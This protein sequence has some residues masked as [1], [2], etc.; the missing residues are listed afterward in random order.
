[1]ILQV[2]AVPWLAVADTVCCDA[3]A[4]WSEGGQRPEEGGAVVTGTDSGA[5]EHRP[6]PRRNRLLRPGHTAGVRPGVLTQTYK[7]V[8]FGEKKNPSKIL[9]NFLTSTMRFLVVT[10]VYFKCTPGCNMQLMDYNIDGVLKW[11]KHFS[12]ATSPLALSPSLAKV[13][14]CYFEKWFYL[15]IGRIKVDTVWW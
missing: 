3:R 5:R 10:R 14:S 6:P 9:N 2:A 7:N 4:W 12:T 8:L 11:L 1:M 15:S 13:T